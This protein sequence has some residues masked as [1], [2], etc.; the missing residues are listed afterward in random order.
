MKLNKKTILSALLMCLCATMMGQP[1]Q[2]PDWLE[3]DEKITNNH[4]FC[5]VDLNYGNVY[6]MAI[7]SMATGYLNYLMGNSLFENGLTYDHYHGR[8]DGENIKY[9]ELSPMGIHARELF[10]T[11]MP[12]VKIG[13]KS[14]MPGTFNWGVYAMGHYKLDQF[15]LRDPGQEAYVRHRLQYVRAGGG[16]HLTFGKLASPYRVIIEAGCQYSLPI[17]YQ[18]YSHDKKQ[19][20]K[21]LTSHF[22]IKLGGPDYLQ[23]IGFFA[24]IDHFNTFDKDYEVNGTMPHAGNTLRNFAVGFQ[25]S[26]TFMQ[27]QRRH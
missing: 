3:Q 15:E 20:N 19:L 27:G 6:S 4:L 2:T 23:D 18:G 26:V 22:A 7:S 17:G 5:H 12:G 24:D 9:R 25:C 10:N 13:Y 21:G 8:L 14:A 16:L 1:A 11:L